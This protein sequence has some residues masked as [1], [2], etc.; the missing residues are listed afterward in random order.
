MPHLENWALVT[1]DTNPYLAPECRNC[2]AG[3]VSGHPNEVFN[4]NRI[5]TSYI[6]GVEGEEVL[7]AS[8]RRYTVG[9]VSP[10]YEAIYP[11]ARQRLFQL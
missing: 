3:I 9:T 5:F 11:G 2:L 8:G 10:E 1:Q 6:I 4:G 7:V